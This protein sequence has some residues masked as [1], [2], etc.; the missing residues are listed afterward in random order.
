MPARPCVRDRRPPGRHD[1]QLYTYFYFPL[2]PRAGWKAGAPVKARQGKLK[3]YPAA[4]SHD[5]GF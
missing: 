1:K 4:T 5:P 3:P 2:P